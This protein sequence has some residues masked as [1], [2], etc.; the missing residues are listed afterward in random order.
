MPFQM[1]AAQIV[2]N[3]WRRELGLDVEVRVNDSTGLR[4]ME[5][6][7]QLHG[8]VLWQ[9]SSART[10]TTGKVSNA[11]ADPESTI[12]IHEDPQIFRLANETFGILDVEKRPD[13]STKVYPRRR[14]ESYQ[15]G[16]RYA[17]IPWG[18][19]P[20]RNMGALSF[21]FPFPCSSHDN[22]EVISHSSKPR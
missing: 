8:Q 12:R 9:E 4:D 19:G 15:L 6:S 1:E 5:W 22:P 13:A 17:N 10:N 3:F 21:I 18:V 7:G 16:I 11:Y 20:R 14:E 2:A